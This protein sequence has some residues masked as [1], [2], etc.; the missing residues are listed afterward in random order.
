LPNTHGQIWREYDISPYTGR[1]TTTKRPEQAIVDWVLRETGYETW[2]SEP[3]GVLSATPRAL[4]VYHT[5]QVQAV[6]SE[7]VDRFVNPEAEGHGFSLRLV[8]VENP[9][10]RARAQRLLVPVQIQTP[11]AQAWLLEKEGAAQ[12]LAEMKRRPEFREYNSPHQLV[13]H[14]ESLVIS[15]PRGR[16]YIRNVVARPDAWQGHEPQTGT[17]DEGFS[18]EYS[19]LLSL[20]GRTIDAILKCEIDQVERLVPVIL[21]VPTQAAPRQRTK[22]EVPQMSHFRFHERFRWPADQ[23]L[24]LGLGMV[25]T[26]VAGDAKSVIPGVPLPL[27]A[28]PA[29]ADILLFVGGRGKTPAAAAARPGTVSPGDAPRLR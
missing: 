14:G 22:I 4:R 16:S 19:P 23:I 13:K 3:L 18:L 29:R 17:I 9:G 11:G 12:L 15:A 28:S 6:V 1:V 21:E 26:P 2:H 20:D 8:T 5:P 24:V 10:W 27:A 7:V 25:P